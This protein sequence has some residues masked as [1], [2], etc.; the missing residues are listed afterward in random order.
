MGFWTRLCHPIR[1]RRIERLEKTVNDLEGTAAAKAAIDEL[2]VI[3]R[4]DRFA[5]IRELALRKI[6]EQVYPEEQ[7]QLAQHLARNDPSPTVRAYA[8]RLSR[9][10][11]FLID[12]MM[13]TSESDDVRSHAVTELWASSRLRAIERDDCPLCVLGLKMAGDWGKAVA[14]AMPVGEFS[15]KWLWYCSCL[16]G[17][18]CEKCRRAFCTRHFEVEGDFTAQ[19]DVLITGR[20]KCPICGGE[21]R[22]KDELMSVLRG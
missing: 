8:L 11:Q 22:K 6:H 16:F 2:A 19:V 21:L 13:D 15:S 17:G 12:V 9:D 18:L 10:P 20:S 7:E 4:Q 1:V 5:V 3:A 14:N